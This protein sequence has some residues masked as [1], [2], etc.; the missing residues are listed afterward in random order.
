MWKFPRS[1][2]LLLLAIAPG[3]LTLPSNGAAQVVTG[4]L[5]NFHGRV[6]MR[7]GGVTREVKIGD[8]IFVGDK[9]L[10]GDNSSFGITF[11]DKSMM[12]A[13]GN[14]L[15]S[16]DYFKFDPVSRVGKFVSSFPRGTIIVETGEIA[17]I[18]PK[19]MQI[20]APIGRVEPDN[21]R[22]LIRAGG[23]EAK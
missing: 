23:E 3:F 1:K 13:G 9:I 22:W 14:S 11:V 2:I 19:S 7:R 15:L 8:Y 12:S 20:V 5:K 16:I 10:S 18:T 21:G 4:Q 6:F 17:E